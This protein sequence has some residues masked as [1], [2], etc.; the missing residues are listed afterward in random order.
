MEGFYAWWRKWIG[1][2]QAAPAYNHEPTR[3]KGADWHVWAGSRDNTKLTY[4]YS[5]QTGV[6]DDSFIYRQT[7]TRGYEH[8]IN[9]RNTLFMSTK[10]ALSAADGAD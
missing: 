3:D 4:A 6:E 1:T 2:A 9:E 8:D 5:A 10:A 7:V